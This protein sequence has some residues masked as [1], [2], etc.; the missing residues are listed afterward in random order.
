VRS[1]RVAVFNLDVWFA[2]GGEFDDVPG[3]PQYDDEGSS[4]HRIGAQTNSVAPAPE[5]EPVRH[6]R[7][8]SEADME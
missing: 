8:A 4:F 5:V 3:H 2:G 1:V 6:V 7:D